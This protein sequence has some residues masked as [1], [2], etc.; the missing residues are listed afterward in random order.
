MNDLSIVEQV[1]VKPVD[2]RLVTEQPEI[3]EY[4]LNAMILAYFID[5]GYQRG[6]KVRIERM[7]GRYGSRWCVTVWADRKRHIEFTAIDLAHKPLKALIAE[8]FAKPEHP[9]LIDQEIPSV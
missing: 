4:E 1:E 7:C 3:D 6:V 8:R 2:V 9:V 5:Q